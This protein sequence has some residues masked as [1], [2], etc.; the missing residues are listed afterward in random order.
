MG[1]KTLMIVPLFSLLI[2]FLAFSD[3]LITVIISTVLWGIVLGVHE[4]IM[5]AAVADLTC[6]SRRGSAYG[7]FNTLYG[8]SWLLGGALM[9]MLYERSV[10][11][12]MI[13]AALFEAVSIPFFLMLA[14]SIKSR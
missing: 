7:I 12:L 11:T 6:I 4:T 14:K 13:L 8:L 9:G 1:L 3:T 5:R 10:Y 2:P